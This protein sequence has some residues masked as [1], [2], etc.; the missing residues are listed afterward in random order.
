MPAQPN[1]PPGNV[2]WRRFLKR[3][4]RSVTHDSPLAVSRRVLALLSMRALI[5][6]VNDV[7]LSASPLETYL[8]TQ[9]VDANVGTNGCDG[10]Y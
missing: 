8:P 4:T 2:S 10:N 3:D 5:Q 6:G 9:L 7:G 1:S